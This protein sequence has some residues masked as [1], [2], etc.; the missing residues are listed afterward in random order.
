MKRNG[1]INSELA[2]RCARLGH[3][4]RIAIA[5]CGLP[6]PAQI[7]VV[8]LAVI[9]GLPGFEPVLDAILQELVVQRHSIAQESE[10]ENASEWFNTRSEALGQRETITHEE[11]KQRLRTCEF[12]IRTGE[13]SPYANIILECGVSF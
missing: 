13:A 10:G 9:K 4:Q 8:D 11:L 2:G 1:I 12:V 6:V 5:D 7:P 3:T